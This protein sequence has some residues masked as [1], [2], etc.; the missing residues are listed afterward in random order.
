MNNEVMPQAKM[1]VEDENGDNTPLNTA[2]GA[3]PVT[4]QATSTNAYGPH[5]QMLGD[6]FTGVAGTNDDDV[7]YTSPDIA[8][9][10]N[11][12][13]ACS[14]GVLDIEV[15][16]DDGATWRTILFTSVVSATNVATAD[17]SEL[18]SGEHTIL[19]KAVLGTITNFRLNQKGATASNGSGRYGVS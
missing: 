17:D 10:N 6:A 5:V 4:T 18:A 16:Y 7:I 15:S 12:Y 9:A 8:Y 2:G 14:A 11:I 19:T 13:V 1:Y 3:V